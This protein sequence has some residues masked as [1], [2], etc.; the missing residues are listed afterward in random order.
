[1]G[2]ST[3]RCWGKNDVHQAALSSTEDTLEPK[4]VTGL[5]ES[6]DVSA[7]ADFSCVRMKDGWLRCWGQNFHGELADGTTEI[8]AIPNPIKY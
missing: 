8:R 4:L 1:M 7:G 5:Y 3:I 6:I 2:D